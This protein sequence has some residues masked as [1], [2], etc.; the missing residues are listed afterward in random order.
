M[1]RKSRAHFVWLLFFSSFTVVHFSSCQCTIANHCLHRK[2]IVNYYCCLSMWFALCSSYT[3]WLL[4]VLDL[5]EN[6]DPLCVLVHMPA[7]LTTPN[8]IFDDF[9]QRYSCKGTAQENGSQ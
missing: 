7:H 4:K 8:P 6:Q 5:E 1:K 3:T 2:D 9:F